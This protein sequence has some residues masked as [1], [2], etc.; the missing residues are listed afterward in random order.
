[1]IIKHFPNLA[2]LRT[3]TEEKSLTKEIIAPNGQKLENTKWPSV[4][5]NVQCK[6]EYRPN[7]KGTLS[8][9]MNIKGRTWAGVNDRLVTVQD[10]TFFLSNQG[11]RYTLTIDE[12]QEVETFNIH[13]GEDLLNNVYTSLNTPLDKLLVNQYQTS[14]IEF[15]SQ[16]YQ[17]DDQMKYLLNYLYINQKDFENSLHLEE[18]L[19][20][21]LYQLLS[22]QA[23]L[24][25]KINQLPQVKKSTQIE[26]YKRLAWVVDYIYSNLQEIIE[27]DDL[28]NVACLSKFHFLRLFKHFFKQTPHQFINNIR[29]R[30]AQ[31]LLIKTTIPIIEIAF[32]LGFEHLSSFTRM[33]TK[34][35]G[36]SPQ[37]Y[38]IG[39]YS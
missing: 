31:H 10:D 32:C 4:I 34:S 36:I 13:F 37:M 28:A 9:F 8:L 12:N 6:E 11:E 20:K 19:I 3:L 17:M 5:L 18:Y 1:M 2:W 14:N 22:N 27:L 21:I 26:V 24:F 39:K 7:I 16:L 29:V 25:Q 15:N 33:F 38:R 35:V 30:K 23:D